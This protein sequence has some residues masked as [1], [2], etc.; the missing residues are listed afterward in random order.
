MCHGDFVGD[1]GE[2]DLER[3]KPQNRM[4]SL[5]AQDQAGEDFFN[6]NRY[7][8]PPKL[9][10]LGWWTKWPEEME[11]ELESV[12]DMRITMSNSDLEFIRANNSY[13]TYVPVESLTVTSKKPSSSATES[14]T[15]GK[16]RMRPR[17]QSTV[18]YHYD[19]LYE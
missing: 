17:G 11:T 15:L 16:M 10:G 4:A 8:G 13:E 12:V 5:V 19:I 1:L 14:V 18:R 6:V 3:S 9:S 7:G 2:S